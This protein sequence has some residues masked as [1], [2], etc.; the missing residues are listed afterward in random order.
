MPGN[1]GVRKALLEALKKGELDRA[2][3]DRSAARVLKLV[4]QSRTAEGF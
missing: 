1:K 2:A 3:L 4:F